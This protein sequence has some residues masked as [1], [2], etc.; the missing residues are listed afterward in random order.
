MSAISKVSGMR[1]KPYSHSSKK[2]NPERSCSSVALAYLKTTKGVKKL[3]LKPINLSLRTAR[4]WN[5]GLSKEWDD[6]YKTTKTAS[7]VLKIISL[8]SLCHKWVTRVGDLQNAIS[9]GKSYKKVAKASGKA[10]LAT[11]KVAGPVV[12]AIELGEKTSLYSLSYR[13]ESVLKTIKIAGFVGGLLGLSLGIAK[14]VKRMSSVELFCNKDSNAI[15]KVVFS[16]FKVAQLVCA[17][18]LLIL[19]LL[20]MVVGIAAATGVV[21]LLTALGLAL[22]TG[23][24]FYEEIHHPYD[25]AIEAG[26]V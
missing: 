3:L 11:L 1:L 5:S 15:Q 12:A 16:L 4:W 23:L 22:G 26:E 2:N 19:I 13:A 14:E 20:P 7:R 10:G 6:L 21:L 8:P 18:A 24:Y 25:K 9:Q 17:A